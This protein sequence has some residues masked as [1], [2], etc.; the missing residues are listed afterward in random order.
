M[1]AKA[2]IYTDW[3]E[4]LKSAPSSTF[5]RTFDLVGRRR[6]KPPTHER[7]L[8]S[9]FY[10]LQI[11]H[12]YFKS[13]LYR[14]NHTT[15]DRCHCSGTAAQTPRHLLL[16]CPITRPYRT[17][18]IDALENL[19]PEFKDLFSTPRGIL[20]TVEFLKITKISTRRWILNDS[21]DEE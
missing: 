6:F 3:E 8:A 13:Y 9:A 20:A 5:S 17:L 21:P 2:V 19:H 18:F 1:Q 4:R 12:G 7:E 10:Q 14:F 16:K 15:S 11:G